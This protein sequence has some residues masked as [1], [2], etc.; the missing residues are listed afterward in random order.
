MHLKKQ[1]TQRPI[2]PAF[3]E[4][5]CYV[6]NCHKTHFGAVCGPVYWFAPRL[7]A[8]AVCSGQPTTMYNEQSISLWCHVWVFKVCACAIKFAL[9]LIGLIITYFISYMNTTTFSDKIVTPTWSYLRH[10]RQ[11]LTNDPTKNTLLWHVDFDQDSRNNFGQTGWPRR[12]FEQ[13]IISVTRC[14][15]K[16]SLFFS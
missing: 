13:R 9:A 8:M 3:V 6:A 7:S 1:T 11:V 14:S 4:S 2:S 10:A 5:S 16:R 12:R 15:N